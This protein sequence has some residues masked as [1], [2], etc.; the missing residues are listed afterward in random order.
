MNYRGKMLFLVL[1]MVFT[2]VFIGGCAGS[3]P[4]VP[5]EKSSDGVQL[6]VPVE[7][8][9]S[10]EL[11]TERDR[12][13]SYD[14][15]TAVLI[16]LQ[17]NTAAASDSSAVSIQNGQITITS[18]G[19]YLFEGSLSGGQLIVDAPKSHKIQLVFRGVDISCASS[20]AVYIKQAD[21]VFL[22]LAPDTENTLATTEEFADTDNVD[23]VVFSKEDLT[24]NGSGSLMLTSAQGHGIVS[25]DDLAITGGSYHITSQGHGL[26]GKDSVRIADGDFTITAGKDCIHAENKD[27][28]NKGFLYVDHGNFTLQSEGDG[29]SAAYSLE[30]EAA[31]MNICS[32]GG[33]Y[34]VS[35]N[36]TTT[37]SGKGIKASGNLLING[38]SFTVNAADDAVHANSNMELNGGTL[39]LRTGDDGIHADGTLT[40]NGGEI[41]VSESYEGLEGQS[42]TIV[43]GTI[44]ITAADDGLNAAGGKDQSGFSDPGGR[45]PDMFAADENCFITITGGS[46]K[47]DA[48]GDG[49][50]SNGNLTV[51]GGEVYIDGPTDDGNG[52][53]DYNG[54]AKI[55]GGIVVAVG[56]SGMAENFGESS[57]Q[58][59]ILVN[60]SGESSDEILLKDTEGKMLLSYTPAKSYRSVLI[61]CPEIESGKTYSLTAG[62]NEISV[63]MTSLIYGSGRGMGGFMGGGH[64]PEPPG[65]RGKRDERGWK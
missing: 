35:P 12:D 20:A 32:G 46:I 33:G 10:D 36:E 49:I 8:V 21:K 44:S 31:T 51:S 38:G 40:V 4:A 60:L 18:E 14:E 34:M 19:T 62:G 53:L 42:I 17:G 11:F 57:A 50:D 48:S 58:G 59:A 9:A 28:V 22:T 2:I 15:S 24:L 16:Q 39:L 7:G 54:E 63:E 47:I 41:T 61:S 23:A 1:S 37:V 5:S 30:I 26:S 6:S 43:D 56:S 64:M 3:G 65:D 29:L 52:A 55:T 25:K 27:D 45:G 13:T